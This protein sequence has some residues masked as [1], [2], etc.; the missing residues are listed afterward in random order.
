[1]TFAEDFLSR[2]YE[3]LGARAVLLPI[4]LG[5]KKPYGTG[6][7]QTTFEDTQAE[8]Y[9]RR[10]KYALDQ[11]GNIG[12]RLGE[13]LVA[14]D[15]DADNQVGIFDPL[16]PA[17][18]DT[19]R[20]RGAKGCQIWLRMS[21][22]YPNGQ[23]FYNLKIGE[24]KVGEWRCGPGAQSIIFG[25]HPNS[26]AE[27]EIRYRQIVA[28]PVIEIPF[29]RINW[30]P[31]WVLPWVKKAGPKSAQDEAGNNLDKRI[32]AY[33]AA[34]PGADGSG[35]HD[36]HSQTLKA[37]SALVNGWGLSIDEAMAYMQVYNQRCEPRWTDKELLHKLEDALNKATLDK[38]RG[39]LRGP[40]DQ[41]P[42]NGKE[43]PPTP[44]AEPSE[45]ERVAMLGPK[46][47]KISVWKRE[48]YAFQDG[49]WQLTDR[50]IYRQRAL[51]TMSE[52]SRTARKAKETLDHF[53]A[54]HQLPAD[55]LRQASRFDGED[56]LVNV[57]NGIL[58]IHNGMD[59]KLEDHSP[60]HH[61]CAKMPVSYDATATARL[62]EWALT[63]ALPDVA[64]KE[65]FLLWAAS[66]LLPSNRFE[67]ALC[68]YGPSGSSKS[69]L[70]GGIQ[71][72]FGSEV[73]R[74]LTLREI[75][76]DQG[77]HVPQLRKAMLNISTEL[78]TVLLENSENFKRLI[79]GEEIEA[80]EIYGSPFIMAV[81]TKF[82]FLTNHL[83]RFKFGTDAELR[84]LRFL[85]FD[86]IPAEID[87]TLKD[88][89]KLERNGIF[90]LL[91]EY[92]PVLLAKNLI[93]H[94]GAAS[95][96][97]RQRFA[98][99]NDPIGS[100]VAAEC[101][102][103]PS[104]WTA[105]ETLINRY[106]E[107]LSQIG[108]PQTMGDSFFKFLYDRYPNLKAKRAGS[109]RGDNQRAQVIAGIGLKESA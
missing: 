58:R 55:C 17:L 24:R 86:H 71:S 75:C 6:W 39:H 1:V 88:R 105:K 20:S 62:F 68:C 30:P 21:G 83:P 51:E 80:R 35:G 99:T 66:I 44:A 107:Y 77:Y 45:A 50:D 12:C 47:P 40:D 81:T 63:Q 108:L 27:N 28:K 109:G 60:E 46:L 101:V 98:I 13:G 42:T 53:E 26:T 9:Q 8:T 16:N 104:D 52:K 100:F 11:G 32:A 57:K 2:L 79:S 29:S 70:A 5:V 56:I 4:P 7:E 87:T 84:R 54:L 18:A 93:P 33:I 61:F 64:D 3:W 76:N 90:R 85:R 49:Y 34:I 78:D 82:L 65:L 19:L 15:I 102:L 89:I 94:G 96:Q 59:L 67:A 43:L 25:R 72:V 92:L 36:G 38:P 48:W 73:T 22:S 41:K 95:E 69:T 31:D 37:A 103:D 74:V 106:V 23:S 14:L 10:L 97:T 91:L